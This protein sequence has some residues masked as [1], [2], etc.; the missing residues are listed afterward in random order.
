M[1]DF[2]P[3]NWPQEDSFEL[4]DLREAAK[5]AGD[6]FVFFDLGAGYG[7]WTVRAAKEAEALGKTYRILAMEPEPT[8][9]DD[10]KRY[11]QTNGLDLSRVEFVNAAVSDK[12]GE[13]DFYIGDAQHW[14]GQKIRERLKAML[15]TSEKERGIHFGKVK[16]VMLGS[17]LQRYPNID[18]ID[19][20]VQYAE[21]DVLR[22]CPELIDSNVLRIHIGTHSRRIEKKLR[23]LFMRMNWVCKYDFECLKV[24]QTPSG[25]IEFQDGVQTWIS[26]RAI[27]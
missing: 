21:F 14:Y 5:Q 2:Q 20:D 11:C 26:R 19:M 17:Y 22:T 1:M 8:H 24:N 9:F 15:T 23:R 13:A 27:H 4:E 6:T 10:L 3:V 18:L 12:E 25:P 16:T 7:R